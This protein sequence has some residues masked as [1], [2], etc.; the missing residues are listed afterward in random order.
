MA[1]TKTSDTFREKVKNLNANKNGLDIDDIIDVIKTALI[2]VVELKI[3]TWVSEP[4]TQSEEESQNQGSSTSGNRM[5]TRINLIDGDI[6]NEVGS[7]FVGGGPYAELREFHL[8]QVQ[9]S[10]EI[11]QK[12]IESVQKLYGILVEILKSSKN[13]QSRL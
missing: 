2:D 6:D 7:Q 5:F 10:R 4:S 13:S 8:S 1:N 12:N 9:E 3:T 11:I